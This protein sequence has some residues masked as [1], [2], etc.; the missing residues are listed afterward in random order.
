V[1]AP[2]ADPDPDHIERAMRQSRM[3]LVVCII[4]IV[5]V[6]AVWLTDLIPR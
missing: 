2:E 5:F 4:V 1:T 3:V 6:A